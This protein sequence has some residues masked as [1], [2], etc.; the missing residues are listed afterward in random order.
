MF[1]GRYRAFPASHPGKI[2][3]RKTGRNVR[4]FAP[5][6]ALCCLPAA[7]DGLHPSQLSHRLHHVLRPHADG[8]Q[9]GSCRE[10]LILVI[11]GENFEI[12]KK[13]G[14]MLNLIQIFFIGGA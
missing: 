8:G 1:G 10:C 14:K 5:P 12:K 11:H 2:N 13:D 6:F 4:H 3:S 7:T 9:P